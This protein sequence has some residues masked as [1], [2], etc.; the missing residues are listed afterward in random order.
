[1]SSSHSYERGEPRTSLGARTRGFGKGFVTL[2]IM[3]NRRPAEGGD[4]AVPG[5]AGLS[6]ETRPNSRC[7]ALLSRPPKA[8]VA[9]RT[10][11]SGTP[12]STGHGTS[13]RVHPVATSATWR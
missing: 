11:G 6:A 13:S 5:D 3:I 2:E 1:M 4:R 7:G 9:A 12:A 10:R 8:E